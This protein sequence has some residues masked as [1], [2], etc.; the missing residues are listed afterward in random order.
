MDRAEETRYTL[1]QR[2]CDLNDQ[3][4][5][6]E[7]EAHYRRFILYILH[8]VGVPQDEVEDVAQQTLLTLTKN[9]HLYQRDQAKFRSWLSAVI[10][11]EASTHLKKRRRRELRVSLY[12]DRSESLLN[13]LQSDS[14]IEA[15]IEKE[16]MI[17]ISNLA[18]ERVREVFKGK[19]LEVFELGLDGQSVDEIA[20][21]TGLTTASV[22]TLRKRVK[23][24]LYFEIRTI[25]A[26]LEP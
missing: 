19:A 11:H 21:K 18:M 4:A 10:R 3:Q 1:L 24:R 17:Y 14:E 6:D 9:L 12:G 25:T 7:F 8:Q 2:A 20:G 26:S 22:Y 13:T 16:W 23:K 5:W 15:R